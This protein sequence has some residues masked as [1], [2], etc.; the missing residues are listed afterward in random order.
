[1]SNFDEA[2]A[3]LF[4]I[5]GGY[6]DNPLDRGGATNFG[7]TLQELKVWRGNPNLTSVDIKNLTKIE[8]QMLYKD[9][10]WDHLKLD[11]I[12][13][14]RTSIA[15]FDQAVNRGIHGMGLLVQRTLSMDFGYLL[16]S[17]G[18]LG[19]RTVGYLNQTDDISF[20]IRFFRQVLDG[21][22]QVLD[23]D[24]SQRVFFNGWKNRAYALLDLI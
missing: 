5:E 17:D 16:N 4:A 15:I 23:R 8:A 14:K 9:Y 11:Q 21:Y 2:V 1:M 13:G 7:V 20:L 6:S 3:R 19:N 24:P 12:R 22:F 18:I 10:Y